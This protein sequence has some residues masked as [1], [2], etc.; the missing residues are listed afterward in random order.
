[1]G[2]VNLSD[3]NWSGDRQAGQ[4][5]EHTREVLNKTTATVLPVRFIHFYANYQVVNT[6][7][8]KSRWPNFGFRIPGNVPNVEVL[9]DGANICEVGRD[10]P[11]V[12]DE[13][14]ECHHFGAVRHPAR[15]RQKWRN[16]TAMKRRTPKY[17]WVPRF[18]FDLFPHNWFDEDFIGDLAP[19]RGPHATPVR[20]APERFTRDG[21]QVFKH[22]EARPEY[23]LRQSQ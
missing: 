20:S 10:F 2:S 11:E 12:H 19:Y 6:R 1:M 5:F 23:R 14:I 13:W 16:D 9:G 22:V 8:E 21:M 18:V 7:P 4:E 17:D 3:F 15:L